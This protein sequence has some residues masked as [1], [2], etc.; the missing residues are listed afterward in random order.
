MAKKAAIKNARMPNL[1]TIIM[2]EEFL[3]KSKRPH[4][5]AEIRAGLSKQV[6][7]QTLKLILSYLWESRKIEYT[8]NGIIWVF[9]GKQ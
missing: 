2:V 7:H 6:M 1:S 3:K 8:P 5:I 9:K 4:T